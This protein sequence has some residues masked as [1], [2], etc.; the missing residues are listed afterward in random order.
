MTDATAETNPQTAPFASLVPDEQR[1]HALA[2]AL[3]ARQRRELTAVAESTEFS[4]DARASLADAIA[5][6]PAATGAQDEAAV[7]LLEVLWARVTG[8]DTAEHVCSLVIASGI[9]MDAIA[10]LAKLSGT[11][12]EAH[13]AFTASTAA[14]ISALEICFAADTKLDDRLAMWGR[15]VAGDTVVWSREIVGIEPGMS[16]DELTAGAEAGAERF[17]KAL[18]AE[19]SRRMN[20]LKLAA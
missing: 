16:A 12:I 6:L 14:I 3:V 13:E 1:L 15:R 7:A 5:A 11:S 19:H 4:D 9:A 20:L 17:A 2:D 10:E 8:R 18:F